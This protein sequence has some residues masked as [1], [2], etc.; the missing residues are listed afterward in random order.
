MFTRHYQVWP[1]GLP[2]HLTLPST[3]LQTNLQVSALRYPDHDAI[4][5]YD[6]RLSF[7]RLDAEVRALAGYLHALGVRRGDRVLLDM[8]NAPQFVIAYYAVLS[9]NA[10][11][12]PINPMNRTAEL[13]H[14][15]DDTGARVMLCGQEVYPFVEPLV[16]DGALDHVV[17]AAYSDYLAGETDLALPEEVVAQRQPIEKAGVTLWADALGAGHDAPAQEVGPD[18]LAVFVYSSG[19]TGAPKGCVHT[20]RSV[21]APCVGGSYWV[22]STPHDVNLVTLPFFHV[23]GMQ[24]GMNG[25]LFVGCTMVIMT[26]WDRRTAAELIQRYRV[27]AWRNIV[28]MAIDM[29]SDPEIRNYDLSSLKGVGG[30]GAAMPEAVEQKLFEMTGKHYMEGY[31]LSETMA[32]THVNPPDTPKAQCLGIPAFDVDSR[33]VDPDTGK[34]LGPNEVGEILIH[35]PQV[36]QGY[37]NRPDETAQAFTEID[38]KRFFRSGDLGYYD[39]QGYFFLVDRL[40]RMINA[41]GFKVWPSEVESL[42]FEHPAIQEAC[43]ISAPHERR[44]ET[45]KAYVVLEQDQRG[46]VGEQDIINWC[47]ET[48][49]HYKC[50]QSVALVESLPRSPT[51]KLNWRALQEQEWEQA[52]GA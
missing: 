51:G 31:G 47:R 24:T 34:E 29:L 50:P 23:T 26:R 48:M 22:T 13:R 16:D 36:F 37:W 15:I 21:M 5:Y 44:G 9:A 40:K 17:V 6:S 27:T 18:D 25:S 14:Y 38:G 12:V 11:V 1:E 7:A 42:M 20:H 33:I 41:S 10:V 4:V 3:S 8:Q 52:G 46:R 35:G 49:S 2:H 19:T 45:V 28:T 43:V 32:T 39:A 30:G